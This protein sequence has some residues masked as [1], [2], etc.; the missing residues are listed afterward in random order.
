MTQILWEGQGSICVYLCTA[1]QVCAREA[2]GGW[3]IGIGGERKRG[4][5]RNHSDE[6]HG[7]EPHDLCAC[8]H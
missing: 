1:A 7:L 2:D 3:E 4:N 8:F 6:G 5:G